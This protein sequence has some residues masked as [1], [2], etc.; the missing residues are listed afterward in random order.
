[1][2]GLGARPG[3]AL[4]NPLPLSQSLRLL[5]FSACHSRESYFTLGACN[6]VCYGLPSA[7]VLQH[8]AVRMLSRPVLH[9]AFGNSRV[10][11]SQRNVGSFPASRSHKGIGSVRSQ[12]QDD[13]VAAP[14]ST[15]TSYKTLAGP[16]TFT[17]EVKK[18]KFI[19]VASPVDGEAAALSFLSQ[20]RDTSASH[21]C[22]AFKI[23]DRT[24]FSDDGEPGG[25]AGRP[26]LS[27][28]TS[29]G[30]DHVMVVVT[31]FFGGTKL[32]TGGLVRAY[33]TATMDCLK[34]AETVIVKAKVSLKIRAP[35]DVLGVLYPLL[36]KYDVQ[37]LDESFDTEGEG[38][39]TMDLMIDVENLPHFER[40]LELTTKA[41]ATVSDV[42]QCP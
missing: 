13:A 9:I 36:Q 27:A 24:R 4:C 33:G 38:G 10:W 42:H 2:P 7:S 25:T 41:R 3:I 8:P 37:K 21:N 22:W 31:R 11:Q 34:S 6:A 30:I 15:P 18:S 1:M 19:A 16:C 40:D 20:V 23:G 29:S 32:G 5:F 28:I 35:Y 26:M 17:L 12:A 39:V 14:S